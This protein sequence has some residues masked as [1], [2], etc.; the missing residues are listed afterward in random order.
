MDNRAKN[1]IEWSGAVKDRDG[2]I[3]QGCGFCGGEVIAHHIKAILDEPDLVLDIDNGQT[4]CRTCHIQVHNKQKPSVCC[5]P[6]EIAF[7]DGMLTW[8]PIIPDDL[9]G[10]YQDYL[11]SCNVGV[12]L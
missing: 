9:K 11:G 4:L 7:V 3:C 8:R 6:R 12:L 5:F 10:K 1:L 2:Y